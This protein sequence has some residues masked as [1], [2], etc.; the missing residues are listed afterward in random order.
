MSIDTSSQASVQIKTT[1]GVTGA[2]AALHTA[3]LLIHWARDQIGHVDPSHLLRGKLGQADEVLAD[4][5][6]RLE[7]GRA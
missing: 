1:P 4:V 7:E 5:V 2:I 3:L 6:M